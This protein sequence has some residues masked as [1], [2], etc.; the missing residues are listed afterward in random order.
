[1]KISKDCEITGDILYDE[2]KYELA[3]FPTLIRVLPLDQITNLNTIG[4]RSES[5]I[6]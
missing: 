4:L 2:Y 3:V 1:M 6:R 5:V